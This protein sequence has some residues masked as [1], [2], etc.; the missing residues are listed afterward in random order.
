MKL[1]K[2][3]GLGVFISQGHHCLD[4]IREINPCKNSVSTKSAKINPREN[5]PEKTS[6]A[7]PRKLISPKINPYKVQWNLSIADTCGSKEKCPL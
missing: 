1:H 3:N 6:E 2:I 4:K 7:K 5:F